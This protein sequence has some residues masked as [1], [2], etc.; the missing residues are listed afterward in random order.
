MP[1]RSDG[2]QAVCGALASTC[3][4]PDAFFADVESLNPQPLDPNGVFFD[5]GQLTLVIPAGKQLWPE[6]KMRV[7]L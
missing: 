2:C 4:L 7:A 5:G 1:A 6:V 3:Q